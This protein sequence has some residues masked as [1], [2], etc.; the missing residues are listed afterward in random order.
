VPDPREVLT[1]RAPDPTTTIRYGEGPDHVADVW[2]P[3]SVTSPASAAAGVLPLLLVLHGGFWRSAHGREVAGPMCAALRDDGYVTAAVEYR[4]TG[5]GGGWPATCEDVAAASRTLPGL[6]ARAV[7]SELGPTELGPTALVGHSAGG[8]LALWAGSQAEVP[9]LSGVIS[10][11]GVCDLARADELRLDR[12]GDDGA[13]ATLLGGRRPE[14]AERYAAADPMQLP[15]PPAPVV[16]IHGLDDDIVPIELSRR[17]ASYASS[18]GADV[19][20]LELPGVEHF[21]PIDPLSSAW[22]FVLAAVHGL[23]AT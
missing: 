8:H 13:V 3:A 21:G 5:A 7:R 2:V 12:A 23:S 1:R 16:L 11:G 14:Y 10:L 6:V 18:A 15:P 22:P 17:Y 9:R 4:R 19:R 20:L